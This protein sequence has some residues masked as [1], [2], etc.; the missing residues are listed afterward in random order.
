MSLARETY[1][2]ERFEILL[3]WSD[4]S[5]LYRVVLAYLPREKRHAMEWF[6]PPKMN[7]AFWFVHDKIF[8]SKTKMVRTAECEWDELQNFLR[9]RIF[10]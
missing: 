1:D 10:T 5:F 8:E 7:L 3:A 9:R 6:Y 2:R 4:I